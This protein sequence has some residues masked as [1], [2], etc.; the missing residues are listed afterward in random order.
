MKKYVKLKI[1]IFTIL[2]VILAEAGNI[3]VSE[4]IIVEAAKKILGHSSNLGNIN[5]KFSDLVHIDRIDALRILLL[6]ILFMF[7]FL[8]FIFE[9]KAIY[10]SIYK[11][12]YWIGLGIIIFCVIFKISGSSIN[13]WTNYIGGTGENILGKSRPIR[14]DEWNV[15]TSMAFSQFFNKTGQFPYFATTF[16]ATKTDMFIVYGQPVRDLFVLFRPF[17]WGYLLFG[18]ERGLAFFWT[19]RLVVLFLVSF[20]FIML[21]TKKNK[22]LSAAFA[23]LITFSPIVQWWFAINGLVEMLIFGQLAVILTDLFMKSE[24]GKKKILYALIF[25]IAA[26]GYILTF[27]PAW[28]IPLAY[29]FFGAF[30]YVI[31]ENKNTYKFSI[32]DLLIIL[33]SIIFI[34]VSLGSIFIKSSETIKLVLNTA[35]P[36]GRISTGGNLGMLYYM[37]RYPGSIFYPFLKHN[38]PSNTCE[39]SRFIDFFPVGFLLT[40]FILFIK[41]KKD[42]L[43]Y[44]LLILD[45]FLIAWILFPWPVWLSKLSLLSMSPPNRTSLALGFVNLLMTVRA[46][47]YI[48]EDR[49]KIKYRLIISPIIVFIITLLCIHAHKGYLSHGMELIIFLGGSLA[50]YF[51]LGCF[52]KK[53]SYI[54]LSLCVLMT[55]LA[56]VCVNPIESGADVIYKNELIQAVKNIDDSDTGTWIVEGDGNQMINNIPVLVGAPTLNSTNTYPNLEV[57]EKLDPTLKYKDIYNRYAHVLVGLNNDN[58]TSF[59]LERA[60]CFKVNL[61]IN[62]LKTLNI[63]YIISIRDL[64]SLYSENVNFQKL[65]EYDRFYIFKVNYVN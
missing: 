65:Y 7:I 25:S 59:H 47:K 35:Y 56:G 55:F 45:V 41:R 15:N 42:I 46:L 26:V 40:A 52:S 36:G 10:S 37:F 54:F 23:F 12:R 17:H 43:L 63:K 6:W 28:Q 11:Y 16:R 4:G 61:D 18:I 44:I 9:I 3:L 51:M 32:H 29:V 30:I 48:W 13:I 5:I 2:S 64:S 53:N 57:W 50:V 14:S 8:H 20:E 21:L 31:I 19:A 33:S 38:L 58:D 62:K 27:Y 24:S 49:I 1:F 34:I 60:G 39:M 22:I